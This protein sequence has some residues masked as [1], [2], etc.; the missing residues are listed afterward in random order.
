MTNKK[1][2]PEKPKKKYVLH[3]SLASLLASS[4]AG[5]FI[6]AWVFA[7]GIMVGRGSLHNKMEGFLGFKS[8]TVNTEHRK[9]I[10]HAPP[11]KEEELTFYNQLIDTKPTPK[12]R[13][14]PKTRPTPPPQP[15]AEDQLRVER[16]IK[17]LRE[18]RHKAGRYR[19]QVAALKDRQKTEK[20]VAALIKAGYPAYYRTAIIN[21]QTYYRIRCGPV[22]DAHE[23]KA[24]VSRLKE[25]EGFKPFI[26]RPYRD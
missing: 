19:V 3:F 10:D 14:K 12:T 1:S 7:L 24:L 5:I 20:M 6:L 18:K 11:I 4:I 13:P 22:S 25:E 8:K 26:L 23:A 15:P 2:A 21:G 9:K 17:E 16:R